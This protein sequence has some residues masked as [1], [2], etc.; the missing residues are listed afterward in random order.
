MVGPAM[1]D[2]IKKMA[3]DHTP[4]K[5]HLDLTPNVKEV[6]AQYATANTRLGKASAE[7]FDFPNVNNKMV[8]SIGC[9]CCLEAMIL[10]MH[11]NANRLQ[12]LL[13]LYDGKKPV[14]KPKHGV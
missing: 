10:M 2:H 4:E 8:L 6:I 12:E 1:N 13:D 14:D 7:I 5:L 11:D 9:R 3:K